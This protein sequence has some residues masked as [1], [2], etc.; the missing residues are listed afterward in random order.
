MKR[1]AFTLVELL[2]STSIV[3]L[4]MFMLVSMTDSAS[5]VWQQ[6]KAKTEQFQEARWAFENITR[7][8]SHATLNTYWDYRYADDDLK[9][10]RPPLA[11]TRQSELRFR[12]GVMSRLVPNAST[13]RP[14]H[15]IFFQA[16][17]G[18]VENEE[19]ETMDRLLNANGYFLEIGDDLQHIPPFLRDLVKPRVRSRL[20]AFEKPAEELSIFSLPPGKPDDRWF[21]DVIEQ[22]RSNVRVIAENIVGLVIHP[23]LSQT[24]EAYRKKERKEMLC[25]Q[26][27]YDSTRTSN[28]E[29]PLEDPE[30]NPLNQL[31]PVVFIAMFAID[32][33][34]GRR[35]EETSAG[36]HTLGLADGNLFR[37]AAVLED[38]PGTDSARDG[39]LA[40]FEQR[41]IERRLN[42][43]LFSTSIAIRGA[44]WS[45]SQKN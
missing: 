6:G 23:R 27:D 39:D 19:F 42:Y 10:L 26:F 28:H 20:M 14:G 15:G 17:L 22:E 25:P 43:R 2:V 5:R 32:E 7:K 9:R 40:E 37:N 34:S 21:T 4:L 3:S 44:K 24:D 45:Q 16:P 29:P 12:T 38:A 35:L 36:D 30:I 18:I 1:H 11:Y 31:P 8:V 13:F 41:L 33:A